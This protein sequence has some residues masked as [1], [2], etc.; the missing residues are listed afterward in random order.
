MLLGYFFEVNIG[1]DFP[2][3]LKIKKSD[4]NKFLISEQQSDEKIE[5]DLD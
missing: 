5:S 1:R 2:N 4:S 3:L